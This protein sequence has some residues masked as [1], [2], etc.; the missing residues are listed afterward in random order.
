MA[1][2]IPITM[3][4]PADLV[5]EVDRMAKKQKVSRSSIVADAIRRRTWL[6]RLSRLQKKARPY[7]EHLGIQSE[8]DVE[9]IIVP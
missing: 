4:L 3:S 9:R 2:T 5:K 8:D 1:H 6:W 7:A